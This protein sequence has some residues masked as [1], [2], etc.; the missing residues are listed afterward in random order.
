MKVREAS[1]AGSWYSGSKDELK[2]QL[3]G[4][5][6]SA[7]QSAVPL[8]PN[9]TVKAVVCPHA[10]YRF[11]GPTAAHAYQFLDAQT[12]QE[13]TSPIVFLLG[14]SHFKRLSGFALPHHQTESYAVPGG[15]INIHKE[16]VQALDQTG[17]FSH[18]SLE[19]EETEHSLEMQLPFIHHQLGD[20]ALLIPILVGQTTAKQEA[21]LGNALRAY[22]LRN[23]VFFVISSDF[24]HWGA[25]FGY[26]PH[27]K[28][29]SSPIY[30][31]IEE[32]D[33]QGVDA[34]ST[35]QPDTFQNY[36]EETQNTICG[37]H[38]IGVLLNTLQPPQ[39]YN[40]HLAHY[41]QSSQARDLHDSSVSYAALVFTA[42]A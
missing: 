1:H 33:R 20:R 10:G 42:N 28:G 16:I 2:H 26:A 37:R 8:S 13:N 29:A 6:S 18:L 30:K 23:D 31:Q 12:L 9:A 24:C 34:I 41:S 35:L 11:C 5:L 22:F 40:V 39:S 21:E 14:P 4:W 36:L 17:L 19:E 7:K 32:L 38:A 27:T 25:R 3:A 15:K